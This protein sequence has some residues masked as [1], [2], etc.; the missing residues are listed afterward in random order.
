MLVFSP[1]INKIQG[2]TSVNRENNPSGNSATRGTTS[3]DLCIDLIG[4]NRQLGWEIPRYW[5]DVNCRV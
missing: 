1:V 5:S 3:V 4:E 2:L